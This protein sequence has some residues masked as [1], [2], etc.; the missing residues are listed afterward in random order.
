MNWSRLNRLF[1]R[2]AAIAFVLIVSAIFV[3]LGLGTKPAEWI[4]L[5]PL[6]PLSVM[7]MTGLWMLVAP[8]LS[9]RPR[10]AQ[11]GV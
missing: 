4:Y 11:T 9:R 3:S 6:A 5:L 1:H 10:R 2:V 8:C 7:S